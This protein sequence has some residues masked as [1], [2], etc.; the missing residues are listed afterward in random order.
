MA[1]FYD[2]ISVAVYDARHIGQA[3]AMAFAGEF[4]LPGVKSFAL[5]DFCERL[6]FPRRTFACELKQLC[7]WALKEARAQ[8]LDQGPAYVQEERPFVR[9]LADYVVARADFLLGQVAAKSAV[10][11][12][13]SLNAG[14][15]FIPAASSK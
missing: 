8:A 2:L 7:E 3:R 4:A 12:Q 9:A 6:G 14:C 15:G 13:T 10:S 11:S 5:A 1:P